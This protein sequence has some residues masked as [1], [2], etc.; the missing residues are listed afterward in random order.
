[1]RVLV[2]IFELLQGPADNRIG[3]RC[4]GSYTN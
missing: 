1:L 2:A 4:D 3:A